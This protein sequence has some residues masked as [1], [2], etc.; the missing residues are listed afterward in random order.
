MSKRQS[1]S[2]ITNYPPSDGREWHEQ[3]ARCGSSAS[4]VDCEEC[5][6]EGVWIDEENEFGELEDCDCCT[7]LG[8]GGW[9][10]C[11]SSADWCKANPLPG[12]EQVERGKIEWFT[13]DPKPLGVPAAPTQSDLR[14][15]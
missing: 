7:C 9:W 13:F 12:R 15:L 1:E 5:N 14:S 11:L 3:C 4:F 8:E 6:G 2:V 10:Q